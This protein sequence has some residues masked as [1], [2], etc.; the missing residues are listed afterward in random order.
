ML[1][2]AKP[3]FNT[4]SYISQLYKKPGEKEILIR[5]TKE[6]SEE[7]ESLMKNTLYYKSINLKTKTN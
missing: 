5:R 1:E 7:S 3:E 6:R 2:K 4:I